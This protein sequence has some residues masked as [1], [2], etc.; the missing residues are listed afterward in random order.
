MPLP[1]RAPTQVRKPVKDVCTQQQLSELV[2][3]VGSCDPIAA[4]EELC[5][6]TLEEIAEDLP[7]SA[8]ELL[9][10]CRKNEIAALLG[11]ETRIHADDYASLLAAAEVEISW[12]GAAGA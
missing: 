5:E 4:R 9:A 2:A 6:S 8:D 7:L 12:R 3:F 10:L 11:T 1:S